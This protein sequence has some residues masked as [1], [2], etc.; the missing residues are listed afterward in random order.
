VL[1]FSV[2]EWL[3]VG[4]LTIQ[5]NGGNRGSESDVAPAQPLLERDSRRAPDFATPVQPNA[6]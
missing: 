6:D 5:V 3:Q 2:D 4:G 1:I